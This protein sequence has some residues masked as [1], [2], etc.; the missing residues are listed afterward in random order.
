MITTPDSVLTAPQSTNYQAYLQTS[1][2]VGTAD[3][4]ATHA[5]VQNGTCCASAETVIARMATLQ[6]LLPQTA[7]GLPIWSTES[8]WGTSTPNLPDLDMQAAFVARYYLLGWAQGFARLYWYAYDSPSWG[9]LWNANGVNGCNDGGSG[10]GCLSKAGTA[11]GQVYGWMVGNQMTTPCTSVATV[12]TC[13]LTKPG[14][15]LVLA[16]WDTAQSCSGGS[17]TSSSYTP[18]PRY[19]SYLDLNSS[20][21]HPITGGSVQIGAKAILLE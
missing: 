14:G 20:T 13:G 12:W 19:T 6:G 16:V 7:T 21:A 18:D 2:A 4:I 5:Y 15:A 1:G 10:L 3:V 11:Y 9:T 17:C 8:G